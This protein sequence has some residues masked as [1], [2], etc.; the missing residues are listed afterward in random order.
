MKQKNKIADY[1]RQ[2]QTKILVER[3]QHSVTPEVDMYIKDSL[4]D[5]FNLP[6]VIGMI[7][8]HIPERFFYGID[9]IYVGQFEEFAKKKVNAFFQDGTVYVTNNQRDEED[10]IDDIIHEIAHNVE[11]TLTDQIYA[12]NNIERE[13]IGKRKKLFYILK[14]EGYNISLEDF[15]SLHYSTEFD[16]LLY[17]TIGYPKLQ[18]LT[19]DLF[20]TPYSITSLR[21]YFATGFTQ[22]YY[23]SQQEWLRSG[24]P[25]LF[26][27]LR[28]L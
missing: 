7:E 13:F 4:P 16:I 23:G 26:M 15:L 10:M 27:K 6:F 24:C 8:K 17:E 9:G 11:E 3:V 28:D 20:L 25:Y 21:E 1:I 5:N 12:D 19:M 14:E 22:Y 2:S 18:A